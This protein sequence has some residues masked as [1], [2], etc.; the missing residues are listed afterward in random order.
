MLE[1]QV[2]S[3]AKRARLREQQEEAIRVTD[4]KRLLATAKW[5]VRT[6]IQA[7]SYRRGSG[8]IHGEEEQRVGGGGGEKKRDRAE[9]NKGGAKG[10]KKDAKKEKGDK[11]LKGESGG[12]KASKKKHKKRNLL[13]KLLQ[14]PLFRARSLPN[15]KRYDRKK[16][17]P[18]ILIK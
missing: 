7:E 1:R 8:L 3:S 17:S 13:A 6:G 14:H 4:S 18:K 16:L 11:K 12:D 10:G 9:G 5:E 15:K 2:A